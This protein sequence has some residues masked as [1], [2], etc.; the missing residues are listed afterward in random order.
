MV[1]AM[2]TKVGNPLRKLVL[3]KLA[4]NASDSGEC[5]PSYQHIA[6][7]CEVSKS[8]VKNHVRELEKAGILVREFRREG[9]LNR[10][11]I[12][13]LRLGQELTE[14]GLVNDLGG[15]AGDAPRTSHSLEPVN[16]PNDGNDKKDPIEI[17]FEKI[18]KIRP[19][20]R[21]DNPRPRALKNYR[22]R[23]R[24]GHTFEVIRD[25]VERYSLQRD[26][27]C[28]SNPKYSDGIN[29]P[30]DRKFVMQLARLLNNEDQFLKTWEIDPHEKNQSTNQ[31]PQRSKQTVAAQSREYL[32]READRLS[33]ACSD[34]FADDKSEITVV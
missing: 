15:G 33:G 11:N 21:G 3:I 16:E 26:S 25:G 32:Q 27:M 9:K 12:Y 22:A 14:G 10:S 19:K 18:W 20:R 7:Q 23:R 5:W 6:D 31:Q 29:Q 28:R 34:R 4:D 30:P 13:H 1:K 8:T 17:E 2:K 24:A